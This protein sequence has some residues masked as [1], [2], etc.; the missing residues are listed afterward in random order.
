MTYNLALLIND[1]PITGLMHGEE[2]RRAVERLALTCDLR[3]PRE[4]I[5]HA[6]ALC[7]ELSC[8]AAQL[9]SAVQLKKYVEFTHDPSRL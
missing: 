8:R 9:D 2:Q 7:N 5:G 6:A 3:I 1:S 4:A